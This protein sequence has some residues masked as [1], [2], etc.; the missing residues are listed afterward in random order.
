MASNADEHPE[1]PTS[2]TSPN[3][4]SDTQ[5]VVTEPE[6]LPGLDGHPV[7]WYDADRT[8][9]YTRITPFQEKHDTS[10]EFFYKPTTLTALGVALAILAYIATTEDVLREGR[11][12]R[13]LGVYASLAAFLLFSVIQFRDG[14]FV[15][16]HPAFW[17][18][19]LG[20]NLLYELAL[21]FLLFQD[22]ASARE[23]M[24]ALDPSLG[25]PMPEKSYA[26]DCSLTPRTI[27]DA[28]DIFCIAHTLGWLGKALILRDYWFCW[29]LSIAFELAEYSLQ[30]QLANFA[31][32]WW[33]HWILDVLV[34]NWLGTYFGMKMCQYFEVKPYEW[35]GFRQSR[36]LRAKT[37]R[38]LSQF[39]PHD[40]TTFKWGTA[41]SFVH[42][43]SVVALLLVFL[44]A[45][46]NPF[47]LKA[48]L[49]MKPDHPFVIMRLTFMFL[50]AVPAVRELYQYINDPR[51]AVR[52]GQH[53]WLLLATVATE[54]LVIFKWSV[55]LLREENSG[56]FAAPFP[57]TVKW[58]WSLGAFFVVLYPV[59]Q[60][61]IPAIRHY[62]RRSK[63]ATRV[64]TQ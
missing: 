56:P 8:E 40:F 51:R 36:G 34:C 39:S 3:E 10:V 28:M 7:R 26:E 44:T 64:K 54:L 13:R 47:Y 5:G 9:P 25:V 18:A 2:P 55:R 49:W 21:V 41:T 17:R 59:V 16:P 42:Y 22:L 32:C 29:I 20:I 31:E 43:I 57:K 52:M 46:L 63:R 15:R 4:E 33:D 27:W 37:Q 61:G 60:F 62:V 58:G 50:C 48:L 6:P 1:S 11:D 23:M 24:K 53:V 35:R 45:E 12:K 14:P 30:H 38:V 19:V